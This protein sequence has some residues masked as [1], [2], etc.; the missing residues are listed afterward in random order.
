MKKMLLLVLVLLVSFNGSYSSYIGRDSKS[1]EE[2]VVTTNSI[3]GT[4]SLLNKN[5]IDTVSILGVG[6]IMLGSSYPSISYLPNQNILS[7]VEDILRNA[8]IVCGNY[9]GTFLDKGTTTKNCSECF[10]F[11]T[12]T[13]YTQ[14][15]KD[16]TFIGLANNHS[17]DFGEVG[18]VSAINLF[19][20]NGI[21]FAGLNGYPYTILEKNGLKFGFCAFGPDDYTGIEHF[22]DAPIIIKELKK[23][24]DIVIVNF[25]VG[26]EGQNAQ[27]I[28]RKVEY[29][30]GE[31]RGNPYRLAREAIDAGA[32]VVF[33]EGPH[34]TRAID[35]YKNR[36]IAY[37]L[38]D[39]ATYGQFNIS[40]VY[41]IAPA[42]KVFVNSKGEFQKGIIY[43]IKLINRG[44]PVIDKS[45]TV[46]KKIKELTKADISESKLIIKDDGTIEKISN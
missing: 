42:I 29:F 17:N 35:F 33:M 32:D 7:N 46:I 28:T 39:F 2:L 4:A 30:L 14:Y 3:I 45:N 1:K 25:H 37:S 36:F 18:K 41:G 43:P 13:T 26:A 31:N 12:P 38:G 11:K 5:T 19:N 24:C 9:E 8:D 16:F 34:V 22:N 20:Q 10:A 21:K 27:H 44:I 15:L 6:D 40:G 23:K